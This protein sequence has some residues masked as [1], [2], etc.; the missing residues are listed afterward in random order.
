MY[1]YDLMK[2]AYLD[3]ARFLKQNATVLVIALSILT[4]VGCTTGA[5]DNA[6][7]VKIMADINGKPI[8]YVILL[9]KWNGALYDRLSYKDGLSELGQAEIQV[10]DYRDVITFDFG[11]NL[12]DSMSLMV[13]YDTNP[14][15][16]YSVRP[17]P[18]GVSLNNMSFNHPVI[19]VG[20]PENQ[21]RFY[22]LTC[23]WGK[24]EAEYAFALNV[25]GGFPPLTEE[26][27]W[28]EISPDMGLTTY[29]DD[30]NF[31]NRI[32]ELLAGTDMRPATGAEAVEIESSEPDPAEMTIYGNTYPRNIFLEFVA[33]DEVASTLGSA[34]LFGDYVNINGR[35][36]IPYKE[37]TNEFILIL[38]DLYQQ[39]KGKNAVEMFP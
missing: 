11:N 2:G 23:T 19:P 33:A 3:M 13:D 37:L 12:P 17:V 16:S 18:Q 29:V 24:N 15:I 10:S 28:I 8:E 26:I 25:Q 22:V 36:Y 35:Y 1:D 7:E 34:H 27:D 31:I 21:V 39:G 14:H 5:S 32:T 9:N 4:L 30:R 20:Y 6:P 38:D